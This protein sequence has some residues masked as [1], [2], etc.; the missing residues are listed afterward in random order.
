MTDF[1]GRIIDADLVEDVKELIEQKRADE[2]E[3]V[4]D[5]LRPADL[6]DLIEHLGAD[7][8][9]FLFKLLE[10]EGAGEVFVEIEH[11]IQERILKDLDTKSISEIVEE[12]D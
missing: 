8:R 9:L 4:I 12:L 1:K 11:P 5:Q 10:P 6:A 7:E 3:R 2:L